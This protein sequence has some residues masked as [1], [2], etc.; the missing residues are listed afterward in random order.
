MVPLKICLNV[1]RYVKTY[2]LPDK[3]KTGK[4]K[5]RKRKNT[6]DPLFNEKLKVGI[7]DL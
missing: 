5:T 3:T 6:T 7:C 1:C 2:L 4:R